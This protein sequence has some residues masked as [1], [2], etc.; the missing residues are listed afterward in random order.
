MTNK[1]PVLL[2][3][4]VEIGKRRWFVAGVTLDG[5]PVP[6][7]CS[8]P[9]NL[10]PYV[11][12]VFDEQVSFLRH[13]LSGVLQRGCDRLWGRQMKPRQ[14]VFVADADFEQANPELTLRVAE[15]FVLWM[16]KP[17]VVFFTSDNGFPKSGAPTLSQLAGDLDHGDRKALATG[18][19]RL[20]TALDDS[21]LWELA[22]NKL[23]R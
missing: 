9:G 19:P 21:D 8:E 2:T 17:P 5:Q 16:S 4:L 22:P 10:D 12:V 23:S 7:I 18:L 3:V 15:H 14:I 11:G 6:L 20:V 1:E 13:R